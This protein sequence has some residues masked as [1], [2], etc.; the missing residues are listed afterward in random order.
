M[1]RKII[2]A[3]LLGFPIGVCINQAL[4]II[5]SYLQLGYYSPAVPSLQALAGGLLPAVLWQFILSGILGAACYALA[6]IWCVE[7]WSILKRTLL[8]FVGM[9]FVFFPISFVSGW[10]S[11]NILGILFYAGFFLVLYVFL[12]L[13][14]YLYWRQNIKQLRTGLPAVIQGENKSPNKG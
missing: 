1:K 3:L 11:P 7:H 4:S 6:F 9:C 13:G 12:W 2:Q 8:H 14:Q 10:M 5:I